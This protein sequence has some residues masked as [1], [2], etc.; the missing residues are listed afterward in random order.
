MH[1]RSFA[2][3]RAALTAHRRDLTAALRNATHDHTD[4]MVQLS[5]D[6]SAGDD[7]DHSVSKTVGALDA[8]DLT[9]LRRRIEQLDHALQRLD[10]GLYGRCESCG[11]PIPKARLTA[12][13]TATTCV[14]CQQRAERLPPGR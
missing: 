13:P 8:A 5:A 9:R 1:D 14:P 7:A 6:T 11:R 2:A 10:A 4:L 12:Y 3:A